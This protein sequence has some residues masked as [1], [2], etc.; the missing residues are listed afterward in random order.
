MEKCPICGGSR[1]G[2]R[3]DAVY[4]S[5][6]CQTKARNLRARRLAPIA[7]PNCG[8]EV[9]RTG[10][11]GRPSRFCSN[12]CRVAVYGEPGERRRP[13]AF[14]PCSGCGKDMPVTPTMADV[15]RCQTCRRVAHGLPPDV[16]VTSA[17]AQRKSPTERDCPQ[18]FVTFLSVRRKYCSDACALKARYA[19]GSGKPPTTQ[20]GYGRAHQKLR[21]ELL[22]HAYD[23]PCCLCGDLMLVGQSLHLDHTEDRTDYRGF[24]HAE[25]NIRDGARRGNMRQ[26]QQARERGR[27]AA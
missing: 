23:T 20:R 7:C 12:A 10:L 15:P 3:V 8:R 6:R 26:R 24:A 16:T 18:C 5:D 19:R 27:D 4:C 21:K 1:A 17:K 22:P 25:C 2:R 9:V 14:R 11:P 13:R